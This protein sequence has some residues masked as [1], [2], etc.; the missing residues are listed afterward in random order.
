[1]RQNMEELQAT[2]E[3]IARKE[4]RYIARIN[5]L[6]TQVNDEFK[7]ERAA[8]Q[9]ELATK[10]QEHQALLR[11]LELKSQEKPKE[12][13]WALAQQVEKELKINL[14]AI[15]ITSEELIRNIGK[16]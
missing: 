8:L 2:Q 15:K 16:K 1:M 6:E 12:D 11:K 4:Q 10:E 5:E 14:E 13:D 3:E 7:A 9:E